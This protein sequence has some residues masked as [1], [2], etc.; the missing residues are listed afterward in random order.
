[1]RVRAHL[2]ASARRHPPCNGATRPK[3]AQYHQGST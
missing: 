3:R 1:M 2:V